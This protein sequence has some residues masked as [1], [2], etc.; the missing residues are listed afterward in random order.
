M[1]IL[2]SLASCFFASGCLPAADAAIASF[3]QASAS[4]NVTPEAYYRQVWK[5]VDDNFLWRDRLADWPDWE[6]KYD[7]KLKTFADAERAINEMLDSLADDYTYFKN[8][9][10][11]KADQS[12]DDEKGVV[13]HKLLAGNIGYIRIRRFGS[14]H[15]AEEFKAAMQALSSADAYVIDL[16]GNRGGYVK[17]ALAVFSMLVDQGVFTVLKGHYEGKPYEETY[18]VTKTEI[19]DNENGSITRSSREANLAQGKPLVLLVDRDSA[20]AS[21][22][23][24][25]A[26]SENGRAELVGVR[27]F[28]KGIA[29][30]TWN[31]PRD[32][33]V[34]ITFARY[35]LPKG[36]AIHGK[37]IMP[38]HVVQNS[39]QGD[40][41]LEAGLKL[42]EKRLG[43]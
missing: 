19:E 17:E 33:S 2:L 14:N 7:G 21:E 1:V 43:R 13:S 16:R 31:L 9:N 35:L 32:T 29:Q 28:G 22:M 10:A 34:Q 39:G 4:Q 41:Q 18:T 11:T 8:K 20:S 25:G 24:A 12:D 6:H 26:L 3:N 38:D 40:A 27:T 5:L 30:I 15:T 23:L 42:I 37:G 36:T